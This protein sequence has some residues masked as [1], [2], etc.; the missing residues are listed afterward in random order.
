M[1][2]RLDLAY[3]GTDFHGWATQPGLRTVQGELEAALSVLLSREA[4][5]TVGGRTDAGVHARGQVA[6]LDVSEEEVARITARRLNGVLKRGG[7]TDVVVHEA[8]EVPGAF[9]ARFG[10]LSRRYEYRVRGAGS[11]R[12]PLTARFTAHVPHELQLEAMRQASDDLLGLQDFTTF[13]KAREG[14]T[15]VRELKRFEWRETEDGALAATIEADAFCHSMVRAL[16]GAIVAVGGG[17]I[18][19]ADLIALRDARE[20]TSRFTVMPAHGLSLEAITYPHDDG[21]AAR[22]EQTKARRDPLAV[23]PENNGSVGEI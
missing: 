22:A 1:R 17:R 23:P 8:R 21:L 9:D 20:R 10:A 16:I 11:R 12:D 6:H 2:L 3:D 19:R 14:A 15:A 7:A 13:C 5:L 18:S 4:R